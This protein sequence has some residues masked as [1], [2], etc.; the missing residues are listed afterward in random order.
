MASNRG[1][2]VTVKNVAAVNHV[3][4]GRAGSDTIDGGA[5]AIN[6]GPRG[7]RTFFAPSTGTDRWTP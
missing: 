4:V 1:F 2:T 7:A 3:A 6:V 5:G